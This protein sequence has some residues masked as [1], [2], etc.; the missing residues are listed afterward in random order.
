VSRLISKSQKTNDEEKQDL[1]SHVKKRKERKNTSPNKTRRTYH[2]KDVSKIKCF[3]CKKL[4][5]YTYKFPHG[6][7][8]RKHYAH[9]TNME[10]S[11]P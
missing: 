10:D 7:G 2:K 11:T 9:A 3:T 5:H 4:G 8:K 1:V 6:K